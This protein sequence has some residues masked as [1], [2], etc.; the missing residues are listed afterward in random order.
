MA[1]AQRIFLE[2]VGGTGKWQNFYIGQTVNGFQYLG[3]E[4]SGISADSSG[5]QVA[6]SITLPATDDVVG[7]VDA[8]IANAR[9]AVVTI[10]QDPSS[11]PLDEQPM[12]PTV[13]ATMTGEVV[14]GSSSLDQVTIEIGSSL[15]PVGAQFPQRRFTTQLVGEPCKL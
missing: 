11:V 9:L 15:S 7:E 13:V 14:G 8:A 2:I 10:Y 12:S 3:M 1:V 4:L 5:D 6:M